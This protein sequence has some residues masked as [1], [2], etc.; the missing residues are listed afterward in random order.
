MPLSLPADPPSARSL[1]GVVPHMLASLD[2]ADDWLPPASSAIVFVIDGLGRAN[3][4]ARAGHARYLAGAMAKRDIAHT[5]FPST[6]AAALTSLLTGRSPGTHGIVGYRL[7]IPGTDEAPNQ[8]K[9]W[10][11]HGLD[12]LTWQ[13][14]EPLLEREHRAGRPCFVVTRSEYAA[15]GFTEAILRGGR[16]VGADDLDERV[17]RAAELAADHPGALVY[18]YAPELDSLGHRH[19]WESDEWSAGLERV[20][21]AARLL[22][23]RAASGTGVLVT[24][25]HGMVDVPRHRHLLLQEGD[26]LVD[27]VRVIAG[28]PRML[29]LYAEPGRADAVLAAW[30]AAES[31]RSWV[32]GRDDAVQAGLFG[33]TDS[34]VLPRIGDVLVAA[35]A[36]VAYYDDRVAD[37]GSQ[38]MVGQH[39]SL[40]AEERIVPLIRLGAYAA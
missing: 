9:G 20:D 11:T 32:M 36:G 22:T 31:G 14:S 26:G 30:Q 28:E 19:G 10:E 29:H 4:A 7:R 25:D 12:P 40:T 18:L 1:T 2:G 5:V 37:K 35:R 17:E 34:E 39:G 23:R 15:T 21:A 24:A 27:D 6:T 8:L 16:F 38:R 33:P 13:R 3:L